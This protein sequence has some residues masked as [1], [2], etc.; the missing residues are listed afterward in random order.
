M[1]A[2]VRYLSGDSYH[3]KMQCFLK[4]LYE[5][6][7]PMSTLNMITF[8]IKTIRLNINDTYWEAIDKGDDFLDKWRDSR[9]A[10]EDEA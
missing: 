5:V 2:N 3:C 4:Y 9:P 8:R 7:M 6:D 1:K 10:N